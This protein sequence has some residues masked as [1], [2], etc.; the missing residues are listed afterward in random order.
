VIIS[1]TIVA[2]ADFQ[3]EANRIQTNS[4]CET[5]GAVLNWRHLDIRR[6]VMYKIYVDGQ[7]KDGHG[8][9]GLVVVDDSG[10]IQGGISRSIECS[11]NNLIGLVAA[12]GLF[13]EYLES[14]DFINVGDSFEI[15]IDSNYV[16]R[17]ITEWIE[18]WMA[19]NE[20][21]QTW[22][23]AKGKPIKY[24]NLWSSLY[25]HTKKYTINWDWV[26]SNFG[27]KYNDRAD[28]S[29]LVAREQVQELINQELSSPLEIPNDDSEINVDDV[30]NHLFGNDSNPEAEKAS[31]LKIQGAKEPQEELPWDALLEHPIMSLHKEFQYEKASN[32]YVFKNLKFNINSVDVSLECDSNHPDSIAN[33]ISDASDRLKSIYQDRLGLDSM[34]IININF[35]VGD[36]ITCVLRAKVDILYEREI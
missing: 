7:V 3:A 19:P 20:R 22:V 36:F 35:D 26:K 32:G 2:P 11:S 17:G 23:G 25:A 31:I 15:Y 5:A 9:W 1:P 28:E 21:G 18:G 13:D 6:S 33:A 10:E 14:S 4:P 12:N 29:I 8:A 16:R 24:K 27:D 34:E 30:M